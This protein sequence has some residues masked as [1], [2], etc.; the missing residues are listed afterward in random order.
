MLI[1]LSALISSIKSNQINDDF[2]MKHINSHI[3]QHEA[4]VRCAA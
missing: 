3:E 2:N 4:K 1:Y